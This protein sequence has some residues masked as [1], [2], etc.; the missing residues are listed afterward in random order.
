MITVSDVD[1][2]ALVSSDADT[3]TTTGHALG[4]AVPTLCKPE[5][6]PQVLSDTHM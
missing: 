4:I 6:H 3:T 5:T 1:S 2:T